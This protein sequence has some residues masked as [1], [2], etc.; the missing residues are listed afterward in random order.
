[1]PVSALYNQNAYAM[2]QSYGGGYSQPQQYRGGGYG[3]N[4]YYAPTIQAPSYQSSYR[5]PADTYASRNYNNYTSSDYVVNHRYAYNFNN[6]HENRVF[7]KP[8]HDVYVN[9]YETTRHYTLPPQ[10]NYHQPNNYYN[11]IGGYQQQ[12][13]NINYG[14]NYN[15]NYG[16]Q[17]Q[18]YGRY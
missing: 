4:Q 8:I 9:N 1:M 18:G 15:H 14:N 10:V 16:Y 11:E 12:W 3:G 5:P 6:Y 17:N 13:A 2:Q 7:H